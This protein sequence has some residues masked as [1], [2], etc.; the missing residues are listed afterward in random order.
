[1]KDTELS[2]DYKDPSGSLSPSYL[3]EPD[4]EPIGSSPSYSE[5]CDV[6]PRSTTPF[7]AHQYE[8][9]SPQRDCT[10]PACE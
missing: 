3:E 6:E 2:I 7:A 8:I 1:M 4:V 5:Q 10:A 9:D